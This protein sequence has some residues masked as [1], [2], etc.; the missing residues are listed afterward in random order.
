MM[1]TI[2]KYL[3]LTILLMGAT[4]SRAQDAFITIWNT[5]GSNNIAIPVNPNYTYNYTVDWGDGTVESG[6]TAGAFHIYSSPGIYNVSITGDFPAIYF[7][8]SG[9]NKDKIISIAQWGD[10]EW[11]SMNSAFQ[12]CTNLSGVITDVPDLSQV[13]DMR[14][15]F[16]G[17]RKFNEGLDDWDVSSVT[18]MAGMFNN[19]RDFNGDI[20]SWDV[21]SVTS[22]GS[23]FRSAYDFNQDIGNWDVS[24]VID[25]SGMFAFA[26]AFNQAIGGWETLSLTDS[27][28]MFYDADSFNQD[29]NGWETALVTNMSEMFANARAFN[30]DIGSWDVS[31]VT[32]MD[33]MFL[34]AEDFNQ[35]IGNWD[36]SAVT[37]M[38]RMFKSASDF[39]QPIGDWNVSSVS[40]MLEMFFLARNF[41]QDIGDWDVSSVSTM[42]TMFW[43][44]SAF[45]QDIGSWDV[46]SVTSMSNMF[47]N[48][49]VFNQDI[50]G[51]DVSSVTDLFGMFFQAFAFDQDLG[52]WDVSQLV[53]A[54][55]MF[56]LAGLSVANYDS[57]LQGWSN[58]NL[59]PNVVFNA[60]NSQYCNTDAR[61][62]IIDNFNWNIIDGGESAI[63]ND[64]IFTWLTET[65]NVSLAVPTN[66]A[67]TYNYTVDW[68]DGTVDTNVTGNATHTYATAGTYTV[69]ISG[70]FPAIYFNDELGNN[71][72]TL[73]I[74]TIEQ[75]GNQQW[76]SMDSAFEGCINLQ[77]NFT[78]V[79]DLSQVTN[80]QKMFLKAESFNWPIGDWDVS[81]VDNM[82]AMFLQATAFNQEIGD[83]NVSSVTRFNGMFGIATNFNQDISDWDV[84]SATDMFGMFQFAEAFD[85]D[86]GNWDVSQVT[87]MESMFRNSN[88]SVEN[89]DKILIGW[90]QQNVQQDVDFTRNESISYC[91]GAQARQKLIDDFSWA[92]S[93][94]GLSPTCNEDKFV[95][96]WQTT[97]AN[98]AITIPTN[99]NISS[100]NYIVNWGDGTVE[101]GFASDATHTYATAGTYTVSIT[102]SFPSFY[103][104]FASAT[105]ANKMRT[106]EQWGSQEWETMALA[107]RGC[108]NLTANFSDVPNLSQVTDMRYMFADASV[109]DADLNNWDVSLVTHMEYMFSNASAFNSPIGNWDVSSV[110]DMRSMFFDATA[111]NQDISNWDVSSVTTFGGMFQDASTF[112]QNIGTW[113]V[114][115]A[116]TLF[117]MFSGAVAFNQDLGSWDISQAT[118]LRMMFNNNAGLSPSNYDSLL[119]GWNNLS[120]QP[121]LEFDAGNSTY[122]TAE[123]TRQS[124]IDDLGWTILDAGPETDAP[125]ADVTDLEAVIAE[126]TLE[127]ITP[128]TASDCSGTV[129]GTTTAS[130]PIT[131]SVTIT[132]TYEDANGNTSTQTQD[133]MINDDATAPVAD[134][135]TLDDVTAECEVG[136]LTAPTA[137]DNCDGGITGTTAVTFPIT[138]STTVTWTYEDA[139]GNTSTQTQQV[140]INDVTAPVADLATLDDVTAECEVGSLTAPTATDNCDGAIT[141][142]T[143]VT[144]PITESTIVTWT[145]EDATG[146]TSTQTQE[147]VINDV[148]APIADI[149][150][151]DDVTAECEVGSLT[152]PTA[153]DNCDGAITGITGVTFPITE[154]T[155]I[156]WTYED[157]TGNTSTQTQE[158]VINDV[159]APVADLATLDDVTAECEVGSLTAPTATDNCDGAITGTTGVTFPITEST[160]VTWTYEDASGN[161]SNQLQNIVINDITVPIISCPS[162]QTVL[163]DEITNQ[164][165]VPDYFDNG[166]AT[167]SDNCDPVLTTMQDPSV[168]TLL[169]PGTYTVTLSSEDETGNFNDCTFQLTV[170]STFGSTAFPTLEIGIYPN[171]VDSKLFITTNVRLT[172]IEV[173]DL[174]G[175]QMRNLKTSLTDNSIDVSR[176]PSAVYILKVITSEGQTVKSFIKE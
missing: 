22:M 18:N 128:P 16:A 62:S 171:P 9:S 38:T 132:W 45:N 44:A 8:N 129:T 74:R 123:D 115:A 136:S 66:P 41:N 87:T 173:Y 102:G 117:A 47:R 80:M 48:A 158:V 26:D 149:A 6:I 110:T 69:S 97:T 30:G 125:V 31:S 119:V 77:G 72:N 105:N 32:N 93:D 58:L 54:N 127:S 153:T 73:A 37:N 113:D 61:Q 130:F 81:S 27:N 157:A 147:V 104:A 23:M 67:F 71:T 28:Y 14:E 40:T 126:C 122:C 160:T 52:G 68:G 111:F 96:T 36:V 2:T 131:A 76:L 7:N 75:W 4:K 17:A 162:D 25:M 53:S 98:E 91:Q 152:A 3:L 50:S 150:T 57:L 140:V 106:I 133:I 55:D 103:A 10:I 101:S 169:E 143:G 92:I 34:Q 94:G 120:L 86:L 108:S 82:I 89:Y 1:K 134:L 142:A 63:C 139:T 156:T 79:P 170:D 172:D 135:A 39:N 90:S 95:T 144:F 124:I 151:L 42:N 64:F 29:L 167:T 141:G 163:A 51:W 100:Y 56:E 11:L 46:S 19:A 78:D 24:S 145:Y 165:E 12:G 166:M 176:L 174:S 60:G 15:M 137:T 88:L 84:S 112:N 33:S 116:T 148:T 21:S 65:D 114:S 35:D 85:Q 107:F 155:T 109:F 154:S 43:D 118:N 20:S 59:Q 161:I 99:P 121:N 49:I 5:Q 70:D 175:R 159:T 83:W 146:N 13:T 138:A 164:Y 168:G